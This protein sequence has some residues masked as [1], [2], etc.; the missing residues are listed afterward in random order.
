MEQDKHLFDELIG[1]KIVIKTHGGTGTKG[2]MIIGDYK[3]I[4][5]SYDD[6]FI[7]IEYEIKKFSEGASVITKSMMLINI[8]YVITMEE[9]RESA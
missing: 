7:K 4:L 5:L 9:Y 8:A 2:D 6:K 3:C 1:K